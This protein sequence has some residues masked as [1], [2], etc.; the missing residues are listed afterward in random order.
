MAARY[1]VEID[2]F[3]RFWTLLECVAKLAN[4][5]A[6]CLLREAG[7]TLDRQSL[8]ER[9]SAIRWWTTRIGAE[10]I[11]VAWTGPRDGDFTHRRP[12]SPAPEN[13]NGRTMALI[14]DDRDARVKRG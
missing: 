6:H 9:H 7:P 10:I 11:S 14:S 8:L 13:G 12:C 2:E 4:I 1:Q 5:P 3:L